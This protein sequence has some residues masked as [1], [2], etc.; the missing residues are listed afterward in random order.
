[1]PYLFFT[2]CALFLLFSGPAFGQTLE[3]YEENTP[4][5]AGHWNLQNQESHILSTEPMT[6]LTEEE[7]E[8]VNQRAEN[9]V[10]TV[11][12]RYR[13]VPR[14]SPETEDIYGAATAVQLAEGEP[15][16][17]TASVLVEGAESVVFD[18][19][20]GEV[21]AS[22]TYDAQYGLAI[23]SPETPVSQWVS[24]IFPGLDRQQPDDEAFGSQT[25][26]MGGLS[27]VTGDHYRFYRGNNLGVVLGYPLLNRNGQLIALGSHFHPENASIGLS[28]PSEAIV[29]FLDIH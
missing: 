11:R 18:T 22:V 15:V 20:E 17:I 28:I 9:A 3:I 24:P 16:F 19:P 1:M 10:L 27:P 2:A 8:R 25:L 6:V 5:R 23:L 12:A 4:L 21:V 29:E 26:Q 14:I 7:I 13:N